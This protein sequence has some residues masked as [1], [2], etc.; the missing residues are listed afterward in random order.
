LTTD[1][2]EMK[3]NDV[4]SSLLFRNGTVGPEKAYMYNS[5]KFCLIQ[6]PR[7]HLVRGHWSRNRHRPRMGPFTN[8]HRV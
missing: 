2:R 5:W 7:G 8:S 4:Y 1:R 6:W 3:A